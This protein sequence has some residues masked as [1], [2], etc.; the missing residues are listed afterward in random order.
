MEILKKALLGIALAVS[1]SAFAQDRFELSVDYS[2]LH[3]SPTISGVNAAS[4]NG[5]GG[6][7]S[8][9]F[10]KIFAIKADL[11]GYA[12]TTF[13]KTF[14]SNV[15]LPGG[16]TVPA[17]TYSAQGNMFT[18]LIGPVLR[19]PLPVVKPFGEVLFGG[20]NT[21]GYVN[22][23]DSI[24]GGGG[25]ISKQPTQHPFTMAAGGG[26]DLS[27]SKRISIRLGEVD[28]VLSRYSNPL[29]STNNQSNFRYCGGVIFKL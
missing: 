9:N 22:L 17:G 6:S 5:G 23:V 14:N 8:V 7:A 3:F 11:Q 28:Y 29:T 1:T 21:N 19:I 25:T 16:G 12:S 10:L 13:T 4:F 15:T 18:Y 2:Y 27:V 26:V 20:S 24:D